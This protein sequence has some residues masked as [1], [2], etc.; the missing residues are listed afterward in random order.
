M[1][2]R[3]R[4][5]NDCAKPNALLFVQP[6]GRCSLPTVNPAT[7]ERDPDQEPIATLKTYRSLDKEVYFGNNAINMTPGGIG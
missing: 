5:L 1:G 7:G 6:C 3:V 2:K 4:C